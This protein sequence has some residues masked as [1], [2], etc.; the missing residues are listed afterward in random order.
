MIFLKAAN[1]IRRTQKRITSSVRLE[2]RS[3]K[4]IANLWVTCCKIGFWTQ[5]SNSAI[6]KSNSKRNCKSLSNKSIKL[7]KQFLEHQHQQRFKK[8]HLVILFSQVNHHLKITAIRV[9]RQVLL[10]L[11]R[12][13]VNVFQIN[14]Q[15]AQVCLNLRLFSA[16]RNC[17]KTLL[18]IYLLMPLTP[19]KLKMTFL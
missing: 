12:I 19:C 10:Y 15:L 2:K 18:Y 8:R 1:L 14:H 5:T 6:S 11:K 9:W 17:V 13:L 3:I 7:I 4:K 16:R